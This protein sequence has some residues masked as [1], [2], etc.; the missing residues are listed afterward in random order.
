MMLSLLCIFNVEKL[1]RLSK[2]ALTTNFGWPNL[3]SK[4]LSASLYIALPSANSAI[5]VFALPV[6]RDIWFVSYTSSVRNW[7][8]VALLNWPYHSCHWRGFPNIGI[9]TGVTKGGAMLVVL[10]KVLTGMLQVFAWL[11]SIC[12]GVN[13]KIRWLMAGLAL[14]GLGS[15]GSCWKRLHYSS[16][17]LLWGVILRK[18]PQ[19]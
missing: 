13:C 12:S 6:T 14:L 19:I 3:G 1:L 7:E 16:P 9:K 8:S 17:D 15:V 5:A 18:T 10:L 11:V 4:V 2:W